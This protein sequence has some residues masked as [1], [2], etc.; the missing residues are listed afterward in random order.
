MAVRGHYFIDVKEEKVLNIR[1][2]DESDSRVCLCCVKTKVYGE[3]LRDIIDTLSFAMLNVVLFTRRPC[4][5]LV[6]K[7]PEN[8]LFSPEHS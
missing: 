6:N 2:R 7:L 4:H 8:S 3:V 5:L 1:W